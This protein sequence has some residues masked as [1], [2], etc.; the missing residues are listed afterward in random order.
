MLTPLPI[1]LCACALAHE[2][3]SPKLITQ[4]RV[5]TRV[6]EA[7]GGGGGS[8]QHGLAGVEGGKCEVPS[9][10]HATHTV[11]RAWRLSSLNS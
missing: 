5:I 11:N 6:G 8:D 7:E 10:S 1:P 4:T 2:P 3:S 9:A